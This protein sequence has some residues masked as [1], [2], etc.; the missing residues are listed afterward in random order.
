VATIGNFDGVH[1]GHRLLLDQTR[2]QARSI[3]GP[4]LAVTFDP[5]PFRLLRPGQPLFP[6]TT[7]ADR[8][9][10]LHDAGADEVLILHTTTDLLALRAEEF[11]HEVLRKR[12]HVQALVE[13]MN[14]RFGHDREGSVATLEELCRTSGVALTVAPPEMHQDQPVSSSRIR[15]ALAE[16]NAEG[17]AAL[18]GRP[19][20]LEGVVGV[21]QQRGGQ[22][23]FPTANLAE[24]QTL[25]PRDGVYA[26]RVRFDGQTWPGAMNVGPNPTFGES[27]RK[28][29]VHLIGFKG[30]LYQKTL[31]VDFLARLRDTRTFAGKQELID[32]LGRDV[33]EAQ[34]VADREQ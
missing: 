1:R 15:T 2:R 33:R 14:F 6:L 28:L 16:G 30:D 34:T 27:E 21:G 31:R 20:A 25:I 22:L 26:V 8:A 24:V 4:A 12:L 9:R 32:Q 3:K 29:E 17:A 19:Y 11:F 18:L 23:G 10:L 5:H 7:L 13:G